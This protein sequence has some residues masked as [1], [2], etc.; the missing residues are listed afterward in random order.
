MLP[1]N[2]KKLSHSWSVRHGTVVALIA[3]LTCLPGFASGQ[4]QQNPSEYTISVQVGLV[5]LPVTVTGREGHAVSNLDQASFLVLDDGRPQKITLFDRDDVP[6]TVGLV[7]D[8][9]GSMA[10]KQS[11]VE[12]AAYAFAK[13]SNP[14]DQMFIVYFND[15]VFL[16]LP[17]GLPFTSDASQL[18]RSLTDISARGKTAL[19]DGIAVALEH[20][21]QSALN[22]KA[23]IVVSDGGDNASHHR[24]QQVLELAERSNAMIYT[25]GLF[26]ASEADQ[27]PSVLRRFARVTGGKAYLPQSIADVVN[28]SRQ[29]AGDIRHQYTLGYVPEA[30]GPRNPRYHS[31]RVVV[32]APG[33]GRLRV[34]TRAGYLAAPESA[35]EAAVGA[36]PP[37]GGGDSR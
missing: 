20:L 16:G 3:L 6:A 13:S 31:V 10:P 26:D 32:R 15:M 9:S 2:P 5:V 8:D 35:P 19:Y 14:Q 11:E 33:Y 12:A 30:A 36:S 28:A 37:S 34:R 18:M 24:L 7:V 1:F 23:L 27:N 25:V 4:A 22:R 29:I 21:K 17:G